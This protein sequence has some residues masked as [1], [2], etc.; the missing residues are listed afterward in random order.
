MVKT[1]ANLDSEAVTTTITDTNDQEATFTFVKVEDDQENL[2]C[3]SVPKAKKSSA[4]KGT[5]SN[6]RCV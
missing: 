4:V 2:P 6:I 5:K 3:P 1:D